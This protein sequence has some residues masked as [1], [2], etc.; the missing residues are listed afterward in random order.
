MLKQFLLSLSLCAPLCAAA[1]NPIVQTWHTTDPAPVVFGDRMW[2]YTGHDEEGADFFWMNEWR[3]YST[4]DMANWTDHGS[5]LDLGSLSWGDDRAWAPQCIE[6]GGKYYLYIPVHS[7]L[8]NAMAIGVAV[9]DNPAGPFTDAI[10]K[11][12]ADG[13]WAYIDPTVLIDDDGRAWLM[14]GNPQIYY[15]ELN[16][17][18]VSFKSE[19]KELPIT[20]EGF[21]APAMKLREKGKKYKDCYTEGPWLTK[22]GKLYYLLYAAGGV[23]EHLAYSTAKKIEGPWK[24]AGTIMPEGGTG[25]FTNHCGVADF[26]GHSYLFY[27][28]G[29]LMPGGGGF[30]RSV[31]VEEFQYNKD[32]SIPTILPTDKGVEPI[33]TLNPYARVEAETMASS[34]GVRTEQCDARGVYLSEI[35]NGDWTCL[36]NV[37]FGAAEPKAV[38]M[39]IASTRNAGQVELHADSL[40]GKLIAKI[41]IP[42]TGGWES[43]TTVKA[44]AGGITGTHDLYIA[45]K[46]WKGN[47]LCNIDWWRLER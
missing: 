31:A 47:K 43:F 21:G 12:L 29:K 24:Y 7:N 37:D 35:H 2:V 30:A 13:N 3:A 14:W 44:P 23:P 40:G 18:M 45:F 33:A 19:I 27:H 10:G 26:R 46:G 41:E 1:Q 17:D 20:E 28:T 11:P 32:G 39:D 4:A 5:I 8:T 25:S 9:A 36:R 15:A 38:S 34:K 6:R 42:R 22:R 16:D